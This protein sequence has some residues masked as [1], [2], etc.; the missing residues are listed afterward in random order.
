MQSEVSDR[1][2]HS[3]SDQYNI[4]IH[5]SGIYVVGSSSSGKT[6]LCK[7]LAARLGLPPDRHV[8]EV[9]RSVM[10]STSF[11][12]EHVE[13]LDMQ[14][15]I[16]NA[17]VAAEG[18]TRSKYAATGA[19]VHSQNSAFLLCDRSAIDALVYASLS[20]TESTGAEILA[21]SAELQSV[22][23]IYRRGLFIL[24]HP[25]KEWFED[26]GIRAL[27]DTSRYPDTYKYYLERYGIKYYEMGDTLKNLDDRV[28]RVLVWA[29][30]AKGSSKIMQGKT[31]LPCEYPS[32]QYI[33]QLLTISLT[34]RVQCLGQFGCFGTAIDHICFNI[35]W[36]ANQS[37]A[38]CYWLILKNA[39]LN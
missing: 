36:P 15:T 38:R 29:N 25:V 11:T 2:H 34:T 7:A 22:L 21:E 24:L 17:Q 26:D 31:G 33:P 32:S 35:P 28:D 1:V 27:T 16:L 8:T 39:N 30:I 5:L 18:K 4:P 10:R 20:P 19:S 14:K 13:R 9:A 6:T 37:C 12:R 23:P 3:P